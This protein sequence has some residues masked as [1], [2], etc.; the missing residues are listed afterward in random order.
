M[1][2]VTTL[3]VIGTRPEGIKLAPV[4]LQCAQRGES[5]RPIVCASG[6]HRDLLAPV[7][8]YF[9]IVPDVDLAAMSPGQS[10][11]ELTARCLQGLQGVIARE[12]PDCV[13]VQG[14]T[15]TTLAAA[16][17][18]F[19]ERVPLVHIEA[20]LRTGDLQAPWPEEFNR[21]TVTLAAAVHCAPTRVAAAALTAEGVP[22]NRIHITGNTVVDALL[23]TVERERQ[24]TSPWPARHAYLNGAP[25]VLV[26]G[27]RRENFGSGVA[28]LCEALSRLAARYPGVQFVYPVHPNPNVHGPVHRALAGR[29]NVHLTEP[30]AYPEF[31]WLMDRA[32]LILT[33]SGGVQEEAPSLGKPVLVMR[34]ST[35]RPEALASGA[36]E[37]VGSSAATIE[38][39]VSSLLQ[40][41]SQR[42]PPAVANPFGDGQAAVRIVDLL[43]RR[44][45]EA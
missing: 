41:C 17:A 11:S 39:R 40:S 18:A 32:T 42:R 28:Q 4:V 26:T 23:W 24:S 5:L 37:L 27:H 12:R 35:E 43:A 29:T 22:A 44:A 21:R 8:D 16:L 30:A 1:S 13:V 38:S 14:D 15:A 45:W 20:G 19:Y 36:I 7:L 10:L 34:D 31:V 3:I 6:Q 25:M 33:D 9:G 2:Q